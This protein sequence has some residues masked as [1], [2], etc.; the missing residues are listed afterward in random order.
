MTG[1][2]S[3]NFG[4]QSF[5]YSAIG[6]LRSKNGKTMGYGG[7]E[8][9]MGAGPHA[10]QRYN[11][12]E[13]GAA[14]A[15]A[16]LCRYNANGDL[17]HRMTVGEAIFLR[18]NYT[19]E[20]RVRSIERNTESGWQ[21]TS[22]AYDGAGGRTQKRSSRGTTE[23]V[24][25]YVERTTE[26]G[27]TKVRAYVWLNGRRVAVK[28]Q[29]AGS[30][31]GP[32]ISQ[33]YTFHANHLGG[34]ELVTDSNGDWLTRYR[35]QPWGETSQEANPDRSQSVSS[36]Y[37]YT[38]QESDAETGFMNYGARLYDPLVG[39]FIGADTIIPGVFDSQALDPYAYA[40]NNPVR[41][42]DPT[43]HSFMSSFVSGIAA[44]LAFAVVTVA[45][46]GAAP[47]LAP[48]VAGAV[49]GAVHAA[50]TGGSIG[51]GA[52]FGAAGG[53]AGVGLG[54]ASPTLAQ[55]IGL[56]SAAYGIAR[57]TGGDF[58][59]GFLGNFLG[60]RAGLALAAGGPGSSVDLKSLEGR[61]LMVRGTR[62]PDYDDFIIS[63]D[64]KLMADDAE[65]G[66]VEYMGSGTISRKSLATFDLDELGGDIDT[67]VIG[68][69]GDG[70]GLYFDGK[71]IRAKNL[72]GTLQHLG[73]RPRRIELIACGT[74]GGPFAQ[75]LADATGVPVV[76]TSGIVFVQGG[77][78]LVEKGGTMMPYG[79]GW[80]TVYPKQWG[81][82]DYLGY[83]LG[84]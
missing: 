26:G 61:R 59:G 55:G 40:R 31:V 1:A 84:F 74:T 16:F 48:I 65:M 60:Y 12:P 69:H 80:E 38:G 63:L 79:Q 49:G 76:G 27:R 4:T 66:L 41:F 15:D 62:S 17:L 37:T 35:Y 53:I 72:A 75:E 21:T 56:A 34:V 20:R 36:T 7:S 32:A 5:A 64:G 10:L 8:R 50:M 45:L 2:A 67:L 46:P 43:G 42:M 44:G 54:L 11:V 81:A 82:L 51:K 70:E 6:A 22:F 9:V 3:V 29:S 83:G 23:Y 78:P 68:S 24:G 57:G 47:I 28:E 19:P 33:N 58:L 39:R 30:G 13:T 14:P 77:L 71:G 25:G 52:F 18:V 73:I